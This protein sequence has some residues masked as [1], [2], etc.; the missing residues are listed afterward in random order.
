MT[1][2]N[3]HRLILTSCILAIKYNEDD[4]Y[5]NEYYA[6]VG[7]IT[8]Q[9][10][11][12]LEA[13]FLGFLKFTIFIDEQI[14]YYSLLIFFLLDKFWIFATYCLKD[15]IYVIACTCNSHIPLS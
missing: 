9:E 2:T 4:Y 10:A 11:N 5:S 13:E 7:G 12:L 1:E 6:K 15:V 14:F 3:I 8:L